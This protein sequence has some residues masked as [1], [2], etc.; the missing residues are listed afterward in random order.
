MET[1]T[2]ETPELPDEKIITGL[3]AS[4]FEQLQRSLDVGRTMEEALQLASTAA[5][6][7]AVR[8][9]LEPGRRGI[10]DA[11]G[12]DDRVVGL[13][14]VTAGDTRVCHWCSMLESRGAVFK[15]GSWKTQEDPR[16]DGTSK[17]SAHDLCRC[18]LAPFYDSSPEL[19]DSVQARYDQWR[20]ATSHASGDEKRLAWR[21]YWDALGRGEDEVLALA[22][23]RRDLEQVARLSGSIGGEEEVA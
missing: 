14:W 18:S 19:P 15:D 16:P 20:I 7:S 22:R 10:M 17:V 4:G 21:R 2:I 6:G 11:Q 3:V 23:A 1:L 13:Y 12:Y 8:N 9:T 5:V